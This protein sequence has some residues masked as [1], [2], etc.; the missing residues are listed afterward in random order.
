LFAVQ[1][2]MWSICGALGLGVAYWCG[3]G[4]EGG[5][6]NRQRSVELLTQAAVAG[7]AKAQLNLGMVS[8][9]LEQRNQT[10]ATDF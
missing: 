6:P 5:K 10:N 2:K 4:V 7:H 3:E 1:F 9:V 8:A